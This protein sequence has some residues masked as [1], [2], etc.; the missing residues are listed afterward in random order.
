M[1]VDPA[2]MPHDERRRIADLER[3]LEVARRLGATVDLDLLLEA[4]ASAATTVLDCERATVFL[5]DRAAGELS[6]RLAT[7]IADSPISEIRFTVTRGIAGEVARTGRVV[8]LADAYADPRFNPEFDR[9]SGFRTR[10]LLTVPLADHDG[11]I[12]GV[13]QVLNKRSGGFDARDEQMA[14]F[15]GGQAGVAIQRQTLLGHFAEKQRIQRDLNI[16]RDIQQGLLPKQQ[17]AVAG[18]DV[19]GWNRPADET[20]GDFY[21]FLP[22]GE[23][24]LAVIIAD[25]TGHGIGPALVVAEVRALFRALVLHAADRGPTNES[26][27]QLLCQDLPEGK[28][29]T[30]FFGLLA[31]E[32]QALEYVSTGQGPLL[33]YTAATDTFTE[34]ET[35]GLPLGILPEAAFDPPATVSF[36]P[37]DLL[38]LLT[39]GFYEWARAD[40]EQFGAERVRE[41]IRAHRHASAAELIGLLHWAV[42]DFAAGTP[43]GDDLTAVIVKRQGD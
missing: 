13:L 32:E 17:P 16:A 33:F 10:N 14:G 19:A 21:D 3:L 6:S 34:L 4:I 38:V 42:V 11:G 9:R 5:Y 41:L 35:Q 12:V 24:G 1:N 20:G 27:H 2:A 18:F 28:F 23:G 43:Q 26:L 37:G 30:A 39:D 15:L 25:V 40:G 31:A 8:N 7:G 36:A 22:L 29:V